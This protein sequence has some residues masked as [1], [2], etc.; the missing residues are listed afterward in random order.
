MVGFVYSLP[1][2]KHCKP[3]QWSHMAGVVDAHR[4]AGIGYELKRLQRQRALAMGLELIEWTYDPM[5]AMNAHLNF[6]KLGV[7]AEEY[8]DERLRRVVE[9]A[10]QG[11]PDRSIRCGVVRCACAR[12]ASGWAARQRS[13]RC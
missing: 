9:P 3:T 2:I 8:A 5:Q 12:R 6:A 7:I 4:G 13:R 11:Q 10:A 1:G